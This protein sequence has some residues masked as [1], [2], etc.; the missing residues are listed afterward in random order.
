LAAFDHRL[1]FRD[2]V[3]RF[4]E[5]ATF[6]PTREALDSFSGSFAGWVK[7]QQ[8][9][10]PLTSH[11]A[12]FR[13]RLYQPYDRPGEYGLVSHPCRRGSFYRK[14]AIPSL[15]AGGWGDVEFRTD[16]TTG[17]SIV[18]RGGQAYTVVGA[19]LNIEDGS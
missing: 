13:E 15:F 18:G 10:V 12:Y 1:P 5:Q 14:S 17:R 8:E 4:L 7:D 11:R 2:E 9:N 19:N 16:S 6:G 3:A